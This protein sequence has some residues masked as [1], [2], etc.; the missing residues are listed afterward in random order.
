MGSFFFYQGILEITTL[1][2]PNDEDG[3]YKIMST[4]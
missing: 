4:K 2:D 1:N 3:D